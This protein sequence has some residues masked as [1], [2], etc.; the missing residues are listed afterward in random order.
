M[1]HQEQMVTKPPTPPVVK[2]AVGGRAQ[3]KQAFKR[4]LAALLP[5]LLTL[6]ILFWGFEFLRGK[7]GRW[8]SAALTFFWKQAF[9]YKV[10]KESWQASL[11]TVVGVLIAILAVFIL[12]YLLS[13]VVGRWL[14]G[15]VDGWL[16]RLPVI[17]QLYPSLKQVTGFL[18]SERAMHFT[19]VG[20]G[21]Y[22]RRGV[23]SLG[24]VTGQGFRQ[25][26]RATGQHLVNVFMPSSPTPVSGYV[27]FFPEDEVLYLDISVEEAFKFIV[28][29]G[30]VVPG[31]QQTFV[32]PPE[33]LALGSR[34]EGGRAS[35]RPVGSAH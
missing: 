30:V 4:G 16:A 27:V 2:E 5:T 33:T 17:K 7:V 10:A 9:G 15:L 1:Q 6:V 12:G 25:L 14:Y 24:F 23:Y 20:A 21:P 11:L 35:R 8:I 31:G 32:V 18:L 13:T 28:S 29:G 26:D 3:A 22:P 34:G 19:Q